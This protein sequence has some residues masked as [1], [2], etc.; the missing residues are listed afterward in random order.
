MPPAAAQSIVTKVECG[1][2]K[3]ERATGVPDGPARGYEFSGSCALYH[4]H[5]MAKAGSKP[6]HTFPVEAEGAWDAKSN[7][8]S[9]TI[10]ILGQFSYLG[11]P[12]SGSVN[13]TYA[14]SYDPV[15]TSTACNGLS[16]A[17]ATPLPA[18]SKAYESHAPILAGR[19]TMAQA[20]AVAAPS[21]AAMKPMADAVKEAVQ[22]PR[23]PMAPAAKA[24]K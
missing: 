3:L 15:T 7:R 8:F 23:Q 19:A 6:Y 17:N 1:P 11:T 12:V 13:S 22:P 4:Q 24:V 5:A 16:H 18:F 21:R 2:L 20:V 10:T 9:E 14:C